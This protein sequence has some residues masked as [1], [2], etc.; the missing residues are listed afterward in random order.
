MRR[1]PPLKPIIRSPL[2][3]I[4]VLGLAIRCY[5]ALVRGIV[6]PDAAHYIYQAKAIFYLEW[7]SI[8]GCNVK[9]LSLLPI[10]IAA[11]FALIRDWIAA[12]LFVNVMFGTAVLLPVYFTIKRFLDRPVALLTVLIYAVMPAYVS[13][14]GDILK[15]PIG[16]FFMAMGILMFVRQYD[17]VPNRPTRYRC[18][19]VLSCLF[20]L[21]AAWA[22]IEAVALIAGSVLYLVIVETR[23]APGRIA[24][25][26]A[27]VILAAVAGLVLALIMDL[28]LV[29]L[30]RLDRIASK[31]PQFVKSYEELS[32]HLG[33]VGKQMPQVDPDFLH[34]ISKIIWLIPVGIMLN[35][36]LDGFFYLYA[37]IYFWGWAGIRTAIGSDRRIG[38]FLSLTVVGL[39]TLYVHLIQSWMMYHR[40]LAI[41]YFPGAI[42]FGLGLQKMIAFFQ[43]RFR[44]QA[45]TAV[46]T[47]AV[48]ICLLGIGKNLRPKEEDK[49]IYRQAARIIAQQKSDSD[50]AV[51]AA[52][53]TRAYHWVFFYAHRN[54]PGPLCIRDLR[55]RIPADYDTFIARLRK[56]DVQ[57]VLYEEWSWPRK[58]F[59]LLSAP[60]T[61]DLRQIGQWTDDRGRKLILFERL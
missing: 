22:R 20:F 48:L 49:V 18:D 3:W 51:I 30:L 13:G 47:I 40:F 42:F 57:Y 43:T 54:Y 14:S 8:A 36:I 33:Q 44:H 50:I 39:L 35:E 7:S 9:Y 11:A 60:Y 2:T 23:R 45:G 46:I 29:S 24:L 37:L 19:L 31:L 5:S 12:G 32:R 17:E 21:L 16:W 61:E 58:R 59:D 38:Y 26:M 34:H 6:N 53:A 15:G 4:L 52:P 25:F 1:L 10:F 41:L 55:V 56:N 27:P 28:P